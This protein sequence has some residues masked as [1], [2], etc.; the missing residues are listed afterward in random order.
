MSLPEALHMPE[1][2][3]GVRGVIEGFYGTFYS[4]PERNDMIRFLGT[5]GFNFYAYGPKNDRQHRMRWWDPYPD[6]VMDE[7]SRTIE[8]AQD[9]GIRFCFT[10]SFGVP[11]SYATAEDFGVVTSKFQAFYDRGCRAFG[12][13]LDD[14]PTGFAHEANRRAFTSVAAA[15]ADFCNRALEWTGTLPEPCSMLMTPTEYHGGPPFSDYLYELGRTLHPDIAVLYTGRDICV[16]TLTA[17]DAEAFAGVIGRKPIIWDNYPV[18][19]LTMRQQLH[20]G[21][22]EGRDPQLYTAVDG[23]LF[24]PMIQA[25]AS[26]IPL[27]TISEYLRDPAGYDPWAAQERALRAVAGERG[28]PPMRV[29]ADNCLESCLRHG[30]APETDRLAGAALTAMQAGVRVEESPEVGSLSEYLDLIDESLYQ[31]RNRMPNITLRQNILPWVEALD[32]KLWLARRAIAML[33]DLQAGDDI[34]ARIAWLH[35]SVEEVRTSPRS[36]GGQNLEALGAFVYDLVKDLRLSAP[37]GDDVLP[38][39]EVR[40][41]GGPALAADR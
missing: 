5:H 41:S 40:E 38:L 25:E 35:E 3:F 37:A 12:I 34:A 20:L 36:I 13:L 17:A 30:E 24:N 22:L 8:S 33:R 18:N 10:I 6:E 19:D 7:F 27:L 9:A 39:P 14:A 29:F 26:K 11:P 2:P 32:A 16:P 31:I 15:H 4:F 28:Y 21:P 1:S 23:M